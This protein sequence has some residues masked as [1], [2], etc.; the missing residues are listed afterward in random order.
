MFEVRW[1]NLSTHAREPDR[2]HN[3]R[4]NIE[5]FCFTDDLLTEECKEIFLN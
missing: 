1:Y 5:A 2:E 4:T 3:N